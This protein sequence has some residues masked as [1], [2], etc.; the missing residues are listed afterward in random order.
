MSEHVIFI[1]RLLG[2]QAARR[3]ANTEVVSDGDSAG[4]EFVFELQV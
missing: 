1:D 3:T 2:R 4:V